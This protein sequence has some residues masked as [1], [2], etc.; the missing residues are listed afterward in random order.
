MHEI[1]QVAQEQVVQERTTKK[2]IEKQENPKHTSIIMRCV[3]WL[4]KVYSKL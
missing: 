3:Q 2:R 1:E 4:K